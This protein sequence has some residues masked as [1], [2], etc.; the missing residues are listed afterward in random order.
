MDS[1]LVHLH[2]LRTHRQWQ[3]PYT[4]RIVHNDLSYVKRITNSCNR[5]LHDSVIS[6]IWND[7]AT[8]LS[9]SNLIQPWRPIDPSCEIGTKIPIFPM[10]N[11]D[12][13]LDLQLFL[14]QKKNIGPWTYDAAKFGLPSNLNL[15]NYTLDLFQIYLVSQMFFFS[16]GAI[17]IFKCGISI[18]KNQCTFDIVISINLLKTTS[19]A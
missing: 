1:K 16:G 19:N 7:W 14:K 8:S 4:D 12:N 3:D 18:P 6:I 2:A 13:T 9:S 10:Y 5:V 15:C 11:M 17:R